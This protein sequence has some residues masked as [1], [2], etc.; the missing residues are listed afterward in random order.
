MP[1]SSYDPENAPQLRGLILR[2]CA[3][4]GVMPKIQATGGCLVRMGTGP[5][6]EILFVVNPHQIAVMCWI[7]WRNAEQV[8]LVDLYSGESFSSKDGE[9]PVP[10]GPQGSRIL[11]GGKPSRGFNH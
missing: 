9:F 6:G 7:S 1:G 2:L 8:R 3:A 11:T 10:I 5:D 4:A